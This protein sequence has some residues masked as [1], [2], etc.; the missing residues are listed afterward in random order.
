MGECFGLAASE[1][2]DHWRWS[3]ERRRRWLA[4]DPP[5]KAGTIRTARAKADEIVLILADDPPRRPDAPV[6][7]VGVN[8][9]LNLR[10]AAERR[11]AE[12]AEALRVARSVLDQIPGPRRRL[13]TAWGELLLPL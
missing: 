7:G 6:G 1:R 3:P 9:A 2:C 11:G 13:N 10:H 4:A 8:R 12:M 5:R